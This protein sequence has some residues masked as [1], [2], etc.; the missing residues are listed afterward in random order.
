MHR[1]V[2]WCGP[3]HLL[4][5]MPSS[6]LKW[7]LVKY[8]SRTGTVKYIKDWSLWDVDTN[9]NV[10]RQLNQQHVWQW[11]LDEIE[12]NRKCFLGYHKSQ[13][14]KQSLKDRSERLHRWENSNKDIKCWTTWWEMGHMKKLEDRARWSEPS[15]LLYRHAAHIHIHRAYVHCVR[16]KKDQNVFLASSMKVILMKFNV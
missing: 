16:K 7:T 12:F 10:G 15:N 14:N 1:W 2:S 4:L 5:T 6:L 8:L 9:E 13:W 11:F 3:G